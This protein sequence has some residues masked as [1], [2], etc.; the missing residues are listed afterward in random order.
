VDAKQLKPYTFWIV[1]GGIVLI[2][3]GL[4]MFYPITNE[5]DQTPEDVK[6]SLDSDY[7]K[8]EDLYERAGREPRG[9]F[10][11]ED[12]KDIDNLTKLY[13]LTPRW[14][15]VL[16][17]HVDKYNQQL[18]AIKKDLVARSKILH[19]PLA[20]SGDKFSW[21]TNYVGKTKEILLALRKAKAISINNENR[22]ESDFEKGS[23]IRSRA[24]FFTSGDNLPEASEHP[25]LTTRFRI[26]DTLTKTIMASAQTTAA[27]PV[28]TFVKESDLTTKKPAMITGWEWKQGSNSS[29]EQSTLGDVGQYARAY[30]CTITLEGSVAAL[31]ATSAAIERIA[32]P[33]MIVVGSSLTARGAQPAGV[34]KYTGDDPM[35]MRITIAVLDFTK[36]EEMG[37]ASATTTA[38][39][40]TKPA[41]AEPAT[42]ASTK[43][44]EG[45]DE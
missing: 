16:Q 5:N 38:A 14:K 45:N 37:A 8:L 12:P 1:C 27:N 9:V 10:D 13:L 11:A 21:Y 25:E 42:D 41:A 6:L 20:D 18:A 30:E 23:V 3:L 2:E 33:V 43:N 39:A 7:K 15:N 44:N 34:R 22:E 31:T 28:A 4:L 26:I 32:D 35:I 19:E 40:S 29:S 17:P 24:G 36:I